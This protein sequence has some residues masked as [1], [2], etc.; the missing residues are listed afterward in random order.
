M[1]SGPDSRVVEVVGTNYLVVG[2]QALLSADGTGLSGSLDGYVTYQ[3]AAD[4]R[5]ASEIRECPSRSHRV[6]LTR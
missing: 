5:Q 6:T 2:G 4:C 1:C 3:N